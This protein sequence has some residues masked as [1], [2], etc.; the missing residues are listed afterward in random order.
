MKENN[1][2][3]ETKRP[4]SPNDGSEILSSARAVNKIQVNRRGSLILSGAVLAL[5]LLSDDQLPE[6]ISEGTRMVT[7]KAKDSAGNIY[8]QEDLFI[9]VNKK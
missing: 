3:I 8:A 5:L 6:N 2:A 4:P 9:I 1:S 7:I